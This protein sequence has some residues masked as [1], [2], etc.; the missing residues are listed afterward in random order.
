MPKSGQRA[1][2]PQEVRFLLAVS[3]VGSQMPGVST[4][5]QTVVGLIDD[6][7]HPLNT[8]CVLNKACAAIVRM[9]T[10]SILLCKAV[11]FRRNKIG[12]GFSIISISDFFRIPPLDIISC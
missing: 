10:L 7:G 5:A 11:Q 8:E 1:N 3:V 2:G 6:R 9:R 12:F 4:I